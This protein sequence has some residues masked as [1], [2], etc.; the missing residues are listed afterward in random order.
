MSMGLQH[1][2][3]VSNPESFSNRMRS[4]RFEKFAA[5]IA[6][7]PRPVRIIDVGGT[8]LFWEQRGWA[9]RDDAEI[10]L[11]N[12][13]AVETRH[14]NLTSVAGDATNLEGFVDRSFD[15]AFSNSVIEHLFT[16]ESQQAM[17]R[18]VR[19]VARAYWVQT[20][21][22]WFPIEP[23]FLTPAWHWLP[24]DV[25]VALLRRRRFGQRGPYPVEAQARRMVEEIRLLTGSEMRR[26]FPEATIMRERFGGLV[27]SFVAH[28]G[29]ASEGERSTTSAAH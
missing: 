4:R 5:L 23:H 27:K 14:S 17:A 20:P 12:L 3:D 29:F 6:A 13:E 21:N 9:G 24:T 22:F 11:V 1:A 7:F 16:W 8:E 10:T 15:V 26:L 19:R 25:R 2:S 18:E 28:H